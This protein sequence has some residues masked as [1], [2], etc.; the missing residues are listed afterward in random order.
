MNIILEKAH[1][2]LWI[3]LPVMLIFGLIN[4]EKIINISIHNTYYVIKAFHFALYLSIYFT[5]IVLVY[6]GVNLYSLGLNT[7]LTNIHIIGSILCIAIIYILNFLYRKNL[8]QNVFEI[9]NDEK[10]NNKVTLGIILL[11]CYFI[12]SQIIF[13][14]NIIQSFI[15]K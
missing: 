5:I 1:V 10:F 12:I 13:I 9:I 11:I 14:F 6:F 2:I 3:I 4:S 7:T 15:K 8:N